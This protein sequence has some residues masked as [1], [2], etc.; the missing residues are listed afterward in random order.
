MENNQIKFSKNEFDINLDNLTLKE[1]LD[2][3]VEKLN[4][5][6]T[7]YNKMWTIERFANDYFSGSVADYNFLINNWGSLNKNQKYIVNKHFAAFAGDTITRFL[8]FF[9]VGYESDSLR[10]LPRDLK[11]P[12]DSCDGQFNW[13]F[14]FEHLHEYDIWANNRVPCIYHDPPFSWHEKTIN[15]YY[16][17]LDVDNI[18]RKDKKSIQ[19]KEKEKYM[20]KFEEM[21]A[22]FMQFANRHDENDV[23]TVDG[24]KKRLRDIREILEFNIIF[25]QHRS[26]FYDYQKPMDITLSN[27]NMFVENAINKKREK[28]EKELEKR[29]K[30]KK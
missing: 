7:E 17:S 3:T 13:A 19:P 2:H 24:M 22:N 20:N 26:E 1:K 16:N 6:L 25:Y 14:S 5:Q 8:G 11:D 18:I 30:T 23:T 12:N 4:H 27:F 28:L 21:A 9:L 29:I 15:K 10:N